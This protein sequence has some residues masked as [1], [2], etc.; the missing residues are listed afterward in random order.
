MTEAMRQEIR[1][2]LGLR[3]EWLRQHALAQGLSEFL[4]VRRFSGFVL[5]PLSA[6][7]G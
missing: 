6:A 4:C 2:G 1:E 3:I 7:R 5:V